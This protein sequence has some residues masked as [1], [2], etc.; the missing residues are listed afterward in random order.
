M[1]FV[2]YRGTDGN[3]NTNLMNFEPTQVVQSD[4]WDDLML[5]QHSIV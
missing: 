2:V 4:P 5:L 1:K 3:I